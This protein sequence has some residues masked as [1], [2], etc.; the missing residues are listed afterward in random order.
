M[1]IIVRVVSAKALAQLESVR[2]EVQAVDRA[3]QAASRTMLPSRG[4]SANLIKWG[5]QLQWA[6]RQIQY[7]FTIPL[8]LAA[9]AVSKWELDNQ[10]AFTH[11]KKVY[12]DA[13]SATA[14]FNKHQAQIPA[15]MTASGAASKVFRDELEALDRAFVAISSRYGVQQKE[16]LEVAG[17]WAAAGQ[18][19]AALAESVNTT[20]QAMIIGDMK[21]AKA[22]EALIAIQA[23][24]NLSS[25]ELTNTLAD[26][27]AV[28]NATGIDMQG[29]IVGFSRAAGVARQA[30]V[31]TKELA[32]MLAALV[33][34]AGTASNAGN[35][36]KTIISRLL[37]PT[38][39]AASVMKEMGLN[40][41]GTAWQSAS[42]TERLQMMS[43]AYEKLSGS[44]KV[45]ASS[46]IASRW[47][48]NKFG[49]LADAMTK[50]NS[51]YAKALEA[52][53]SRTKAL[54]TMQRELNAVLESNPRSLQRMWVTLQNALTDVIQP[55]IP[56]LIY[57]AKKLA[58][59]AQAFANMNPHMQKLILM[60]LGVIAVIG[61]LAKL[62]G[63]TGVLLGVTGT[64][65]R[66]FAKIM[67]LTAVSSEVVNV[68]V[69]KNRKS[70]LQLLASMLPKPIQNFAKTLGIELPVAAEVAEESV[71]K[72]RRGVLQFLASLV[73]TP[74]AFFYNGVMTIFG[75]LAAESKKQFFAIASYFGASNLAMEKRARAHRV[76]MAPFFFSGY[77][78]GLW[79]SF[80]NLVVGTST[81]ASNAVIAIEGKKYL[82]LNAAAAV[83]E[84]A[85]VFVVDKFGQARVASEAKTAAS[86]LFTVN[87]A[88]EAVVKAEQAQAARR[89][90]IADSMGRVEVST[91]QATQAQRLIALN[92]AAA[93]RVAAE[94]VWEGQ[95]VFVAGEAGA[96]RVSAE[97]AAEFRRVI[98]VNKFGT[99]R[100]T[101]EAAAQARLTELIAGSSSGRLALESAEQAQRTFVTTSGGTTRAAAEVAAEAQRVFVVESSGLI[102]TKAEVEASAARIAAAMRYANTA[103]RVEQMT[104]AGL[105]AALSA[106]NGN[107]AKAWAAYHQYLL[108][109]EE[110]YNTRM[111]A[112]ESAA[113][114]QLFAEDVA[115]STRRAAVWEAYY[116][117]LAQVAAASNAALRGIEAGSF[118]SLLAIES[119]G[120][121][122]RTTAAEAGAAQRVLI[123][124]AESRARAAT[125][126]SGQSALLAI[127]AGGQAKSAALV[128]AGG[129]AQAA[130]ATKSSSRIL[131]IITGLGSRL[132]KITRTAMMFFVSPWGLAVAAVIGILYVFK[133]QIADA[134]DK[135]VNQFKK[136]GSDLHK[137]MVEVV[138]SIVGAFN[139]LPQGVQGALLAVVS[140]V[141]AAAMAVYGWFQYINPFAH[142]SPSLVENVTRGMAAVN[143]QFASLSNIK[144][145]TSSAYAEIKR[146]GKLTAS[147]G[148]S[149][150][151]AQQAEDRATIKK[152]GSSA[153]LGSYD[154]LTKILNGLTPIYNR[155]N[156]QMQAQQR[157]VDT[158]QV[159]VTKANNAL[160]GQEKILNK[161]QDKLDG[162]Q[163][164]VDAAKQSMQDFA[165][166]PLVGMR[167]MED[168]IFANTVAQNKL[169]LSMMDMEDAV[170]TL[171][172]VR[173]KIEAING[174][175]E[176]LRGEQS[177]L[178]SAG[179]GSDITAVYDQ[180][181][182]GLE[183]QKSQ[184]QKNNTAINEMQSALEALQRQADRLDL[185]K[186]LKFD[187][188]QHQIQR[189]A[190][191]SEE[192][193][194]GTVIAG[195][196]SAR[197]Q[198]AK[199]SPMVDTAT[200]AVA[201]QQGVVDK[202]TAS[203]D[204]LQDRLDTENQKLDAVKAKYDEV[205]NAIQA[206]NS[207]LG[208]V[209]SS[210]GKVNEAMA[211]KKGK[212]GGSE[213]ESPGL[214]N[215]RAAQKGDF[216]DKGGMGI[217]IRTDWSSEQAAVDKM[218]EKLQKDTAG[219]FAG[220]NPFAPLKKKAIAAWEWIKSHTVSAA[221]SIGE[222]F[223]SILGSG[224]ASK[225]IDKIQSAFRALGKFLTKIAKDIGRFIAIL[226]DLLGPD[227]TK[228]FRNLWKGIQD[229]ID[230]VGPEVAKFVPLFKPAWQAIKNLWTIAK[231]ILALM[232]VRMIFFAKIIASVVA[233]IIRPALKALGTI[234]AATV[235]TVRG[236]IELLIG[237]LTLDPAMIWHGIVDVIVGPF[238]ALWGLIWG[239]ISVVANGIKGFVR[240]IFNFFVWLYDVLIGHSVIPDIVDGIVRVFKT[241]A[242][243][244]KWIWNNIL[245]PIYEFFRDLWSKYVAPSLRLWWSGI[246][247]IWSALKAVG[248]WM[249]DNVLNPVVGR[250]KTLWTDVK[251]NLTG[252]WGGIKTAFGALKGLAKWVG[253]N[254]FGPVKDKIIS[255]WKS[256][257]DWFT[258]NSGIFKK[259]ISAVMN[260]VINAI[261]AMIRGLNS[262]A[263]N[264][265]GLSWHINLIPKL[266]EGGEIA[267]RRVGSGFK[268]NGA[269]AIVGE[270]KANYPEYVIPTDP[271]H[272]RRATALLASA[273]SR[274]GSAVIPSVNSRGAWGDTTSEM[275]RVVKANPS[276]MSGVPQFAIG[277]ILGNIGDILS[278]GA[279]TVKDLAKGGA[280]WIKG[281]IKTLASAPFKAFKAVA[282]HYIDKIGWDIPRD[283][284]NWALNKVVDWVS[285]A[286]DVYEK[287]AKG[288][289][290]ELGG[291]PKVEKA[292][293]WA[294][295]QQ[296]KPYIWGG[297]GPDGYDCSGFMSALTNVING[298]SP[299]RRIGATGT[300]PWGGFKS[301]A[302][303]GFT[304]G[305]AKNYGGSG[306]GHTAGTLGN[307]NVE[308]R[309]GVG[310]IV[311]PSARGYLDSGFTN[312]A[313]LTGLQYGGIVRR[314]A[315]GLIARIGEG[316]YDEAVTPLPHG[317][318]SSG[319]AFGSKSETKEFHFHGDLSFPNI[320]S[321]DDAES[322]IR[323][324]EILSKD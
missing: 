222:S 84:K 8:A 148:L 120:N 269:R 204:R 55:L 129:Q 116:A 235:Q 277:G 265:P 165:S 261:N 319:L 237:I 57:L 79:K 186:S 289:K 16:V 77:L 3:T 15:G 65:F 205:N 7:N 18:S 323:N 302:K 187:E 168:Q 212:K 106:A 203:R 58:D 305:W 145:Y 286:D 150:A 36:L 117:Y 105:L 193:T 131:G 90:F 86:R 11:V 64:A 218:V 46:V 226:W 152:S 164:K 313:G 162:Y 142:H 27:N 122:S 293:A 210:A 40:I 171:D 299:Y 82:E 272:R 102:R 67:G 68:S 236:V 321:G 115:W 88:G 158:W 196:Q 74:V 223:S 308:S 51:F 157:V 208:D 61:P 241:L 262:I 252:W 62:V 95:R 118:G 35:A 89:V 113:Q 311:G 143:N 59:M 221:K 91:E 179:A 10:K 211:K 166:A 92:A 53:G 60:G 287:K 242:S 56:Y 180:Q 274:M 4:A 6:G 317:W 229:V 119:G 245:K 228:I 307:T 141:K 151:K 169:R 97:N 147:L 281:S 278:N 233:D 111:A 107:K 301:G 96:A 254:V 13:A 73:T 273:A 100:V 17:A 159:A 78:I 279:G 270:G 183:E 32:A 50:K 33:P 240:G 160:D 295:T 290:T 231:P 255:I 259:P 48:I 219:A 202:L 146:F 256:I 285:I 41:E 130:A 26:L 194:F 153:A 267:K 303:T 288:V 14:Y 309:G 39:E 227:I 192:L 268:T 121:A 52:T 93:Q 280:K 263:E 109:L 123:A 316:S 296:G 283:T 275:A 282:K 310:V 133:K 125:A 298:H 246:K 234:F 177:S 251:T 134:W 49:I 71:K 140:I 72:T 2:G 42:A 155:L 132:F 135:I 300:M 238:K 297:V 170:G 30:G 21:S 175:Q 12:G 200:A 247:T 181:I 9:G 139:R 44:A 163:S 312:Y 24:Y 173:A 101:N 99:A 114:A 167:A 5:S 172:D 266:A 1:N 37:S 318:R 324:L 23:Q 306:I 43:E 232:A 178:R 144:K 257:R 66:E 124:G 112:L 230:R 103:V 156:G 291:G 314:R 243:F 126:I 176:M 87:S 189:A 154:R 206:I 76:A 271:T 34:A 249:W 198:I 201:K 108:G 31:S 207:S 188:L 320:K 98:S 45:V 161:L 248:K 136:P 215:F 225:G 38:G 253:D 127:E 94:K 174:A 22:T 47:Q 63:A 190:D 292:L 28:E 83:G 80:W 216:P 29:L 304:V 81:V 220:L 54:A 70:I 250:V 260:I 294:K 239:S 199:Y 214:H 149:A 19:G 110:S 182:K 25:A 264:L 191:T 315:G 195:I 224:D 197:D 85:R 128:V 104:Q 20:M 276:A 284:T 322:F 209:V 185:V 184:Y 258:D 213:Y 217:P 75:A 138:N 69:K 244:P 137:F